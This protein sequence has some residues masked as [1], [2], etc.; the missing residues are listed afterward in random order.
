MNCYFVNTGHANLTCSTVSFNCWHRFHLLFLFV[1]FLLHDTLFVLPAL[2]LLLSHFQF[3][4]PTLPSTATG[5]RSQNCEKRQLASSCPSVRLSAQ[6][7]SAPT[8]RIFIEFYT[9]GPFF[10]KICRENSSFFNSDNNNGHFTCRPIYIF[11]HISL[12]SS[13]N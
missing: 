1:I 3:P 11:D 2:V 9:W 6:N 12:I 13:Y 8:T 7:N 10:S 4:L 5:A